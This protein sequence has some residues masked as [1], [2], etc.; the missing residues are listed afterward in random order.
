MKTQI[1]ARNA[2]DQQLVLRKE[3]LVN[4]AKSSKP[5]LKEITTTYTTI[6]TTSFN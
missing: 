2:S 1:K 4:L 6:T 5:K 3:R